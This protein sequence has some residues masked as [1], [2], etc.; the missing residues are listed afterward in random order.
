MRINA[1]ERGF[2]DREKGKV[3]CFV[4]ENPLDPRQKI[5][6]TMKNQGR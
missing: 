1:D 6:F 4:R 5:S 3:I 2:A